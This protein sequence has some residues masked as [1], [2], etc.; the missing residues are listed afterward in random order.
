VSFC[1][2][3]WAALWFFFLPLHFISIEKKKQCAACGSDKKHDG[4]NHRRVGV[5]EGEAGIF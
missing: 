5:G 3:G 4:K 1:L 2:W